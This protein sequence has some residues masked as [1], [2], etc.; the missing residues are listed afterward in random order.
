M[1]LELKHAKELYGNEI[2][3]MEAIIASYGELKLLREKSGD[4][5]EYIPQVRLVGIPFGLLREVFKILGAKPADQNSQI[6]PVTKVNCCIR[7]VA[8]LE[9]LLRQIRLDPKKVER[10]QRVLEESARKVGIRY[11]KEKEKWRYFA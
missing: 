3:Y 6:T 4:D 9:S 11:R 5:W 8:G 1:V 10:Y 2:E 7:G